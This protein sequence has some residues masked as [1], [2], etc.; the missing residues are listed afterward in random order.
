[1][2]RLYRGANRMILVNAVTEPNGVIR[3]EEPLP[4]ESILI[5]GSPE[6]YACYFRDDE[7]PNEYAF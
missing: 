2:L 6:G 5:V 7:L 3:P 4:N 1:M